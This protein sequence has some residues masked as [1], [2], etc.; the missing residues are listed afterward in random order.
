MKYYFGKVGQALITIILVTL[1]S[2]ILV[3]LSKVDPATAYCQRQYIISEEKINE[4]K[5]TMGLNKPIIEQYKIWAINILKGDFGISYVSGKP[6]RPELFQA[7]TYTTKIVLLATLIQGLGSLIFG[8]M[9]YIFRSRPLGKVFHIVSILGISIPSFIIAGSILEIF[10]NYLGIIKISGNEGLAKYLP[11]AI[12]FSISGIAYFGKLLMTN[13][14]NLMK[15]KDVFYARTLGL[16][17]R[18]ILKYFIMK[19]AILILLPSFMQMM[20]MCFAG[21]ILVEQVFGLPGIGGLII[22]SVLMRDAPTIYGIILLLGI[23]FVLFDTMA[24]LIN[25]KGAYYVK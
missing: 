2:F 24:N 21:S 25:E 12:S 7:M 19:R 14:E 6:V 3:N 5:E 22:D 13:I 10:A 4:V 11:A 15:G 16:T 8:Y 20:A 9:F 1:L 18:E 23:T 17:E